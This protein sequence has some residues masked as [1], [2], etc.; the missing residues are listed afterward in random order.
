M[1]ALKLY[2]FIPTNPAPPPQKTARAFR[3]GFY[4]R[5]QE[6]QGFIL[7]LLKTDSFPILSSL[8]SPFD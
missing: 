5:A 8:S 6:Q 2:V 4:P 3:A 7:D 1:S